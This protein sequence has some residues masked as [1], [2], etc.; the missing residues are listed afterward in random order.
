MLRVPSLSF[1]HPPKGQPEGEPFGS[2]AWVAAFRLTWLGT[3]AEGSGHVTRWRARKAN[4]RG[5]MPGIRLTMQYGED[6]R[7][8]NAI[9]TNDTENT[10]DW[11]LAELAYGPRTVA[12]L[13]EQMLATMDE[14]PAGELH[15]IKERL[16][17]ALLRM[18]RPEDGSVTKEGKT[19]PAVRWRLE[20]PI[21]LLAGE[22]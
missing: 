5:H 13:A 9:V 11:L 22:S 16:G 3:H 10:R 1:G 7:P 18:S 15:R 2:F 19:G 17:Q 21:R 4:E 14:P 12:D 6:E 20:R 8:C